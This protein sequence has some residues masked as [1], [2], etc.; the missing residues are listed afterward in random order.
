M[1]KLIAALLFPIAAYGQT[2]ATYSSA[3][4]ILNIP[5]LSADGTTY[6]N[7]SVFV[8]L[9]NPKSGSVLNAEGTFDGI[10]QCNSD[11]TIFMIAHLSSQSASGNCSAYNGTTKS[12]IITGLST[13]PQPF[14]YAIGCSVKPTSG[15]SYFSGTGPDGKLAQLFFNNT[16]NFYW[17][18]STKSA[19][20]SKVY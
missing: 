11:G 6:G 20:C 12:A 19:S 17:S 2:A 7:V 5:S 9:G 1:K 3:T 15:S 10:Y 18:G 13:G 16:N 14:Q 8:D 4:N